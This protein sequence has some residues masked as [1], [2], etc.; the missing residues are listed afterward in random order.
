[1]TIRDDGT[2]DSDTKQDIEDA[3]IQDAKNYW[4]DDL[5]D[6]EEKTIRQFYEPIA[7]RFAVSQQ[8]I[9][10]VLASS[11]IDYAEDGGLDLLTALIGIRRQPALKATGTVTFKHAEDGST[12]SQDYT[13]PEGTRVQTNS[14][15]PVRFDTTK[16]VVLSSGTASVDAPVEAIGGGIRGNVGANTIV[17]MPDPPLGIKVVNN[18]AETT[19]GKDEETDESLRE[20]AKENLGSGS[21]ASASALINTARALE[22]VKGVSIFINDTSTDNTGSGGLPDHSFELVVQDGTPSEIAQMILDTKAAG[23]NAY[24]GAHGTTQTVTA[25]LPNGQTHD[26]SFST[27][28]QVQIYVDCDLKVTDEYEGDDAL[29]DSIVR[30]LGGTLSSNNDEGGDLLVGEDVLYGMVEYA[31]RDTDGVYDVNSLYID[32]SSSPA[33]TSDIAIADDSIAFGDATDSSITIATT[34]VSF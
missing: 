12:A 23:D 14:D 11:Q 32:T 7:E 16:S 1:M 22:G 28:T 8:D 18:A 17:V 21:R 30:Y 26:V 9:A 31:V 13:V 33:A 34:T 10:A 3:L 19:G 20:R 25:E 15:N 27:P 29:R 5:N 4:G 2:F 6:N 24:S